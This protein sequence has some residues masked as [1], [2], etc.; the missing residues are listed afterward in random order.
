MAGGG[1]A[2]VGFNGSVALQTHMT[3]SRLT[4]PEVLETRYPVRLERFAIR[5]GSGGDGQWRGGDGLERTI[6]FLEPMTVSLI[7]GSRRVPPFGLH[8]GDN[9]ACGVN[10]RLGIDGA[11]QR[12]AGAVQLKLKA[13]EA[14]K[15]L[16]PGGGGTGDSRLR[17]AEC[18]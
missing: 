5:A 8:G 16:T 9:G 2:G 13:G 14:I 1:G 6:R 17:D 3:N 18:V 4:D 10:L 15:L 7:S 11:E 12:L